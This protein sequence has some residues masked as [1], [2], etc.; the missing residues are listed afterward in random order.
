[1]KFRMIPILLLAA[2]MAGPVA[3]A[4]TSFEH[5]PGT[6]SHIKGREA[7]DAGRHWQ[8]MQHFLSSAHWAD[9]MSQFNI[10]VMYFN[11][12]GVD[13]DHSRGWAW[14]ELSAERRYPQ[15]VE[16]ADRIWAQL[17][18]A[19]REQGRRILEQELLPAYGDEMAV[20][21][22]A[23]RMQEQRRTMTGSRM[24][25][26]GIMEI[27]VPD[28]SPRSRTEYYKDENWDFYALLELEAKMLE[29]VYRGRVEVGEFEVIE[30]EE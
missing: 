24:G 11:G 7:Y 13:A 12:E 19:Q 1:M 25:N 18:D 26:P 21:R 23:R 8:A 3:F 27:Y 30:P 17:D 20:P 28:R 10:G 15:M 5:A 6:S 2:V 14:M 9:K 4:Q 29:G 16:M 22:T